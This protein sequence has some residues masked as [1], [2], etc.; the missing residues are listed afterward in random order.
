MQN[1]IKQIHTN[2]FVRLAHKNKEIVM[3][4]RIKSPPI[5]GVPA[6]L[7]KWFSGP[8]RRI[9]WPIGWKDN[10]LSIINPPKINEKN[11]DVKIAAPALNVI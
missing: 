9:G 1:K 3:L 7:I 4:E 6:F 8:S 2:L 10:S 5:V 11:N